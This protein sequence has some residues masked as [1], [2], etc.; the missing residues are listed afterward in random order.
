MSTRTGITVAY[1][2][3][4]L[5]L[6]GGVVW[7]LLRQ[8]SL[9]DR[10]PQIPD[11][12]KL[13]RRGPVFEPFPY[14]RSA[15][16][17]EASRRRLARA[18]IADARDVP[19]L[20]VR[21]NLVLL[22]KANWNDDSLDYDRA[23]LARRRLENMIVAVTKLPSTESPNAVS[24]VVVGTEHRVERTVSAASLRDLVNEALKGTKSK[25]ASPPA[26]ELRVR[27][28]D[29]RI[30][31]SENDKDKNDEE[32]NGDDMSDEQ[33]TSWP[34][35]TIRLD[36]LVGAGPKLFDDKRRRDRMRRHLGERGLYRFKRKIYEVHAVPSKP[37]TDTKS[38]S[39]SR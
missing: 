12:R 20:E 34:F 21:G 11:D 28:P 16:V 7:L 29:P 3:L 35:A 17:I 1:A 30:A 22:N 6:L 32:K 39:P 23:L 36:Q 15:T 24:L 2:L 25:R 37:P 10:E 13:A 38:K 31:T 26:V 14:D 18:E 33:I 5:G 27:T 4:L 8:R 19:L 9:L